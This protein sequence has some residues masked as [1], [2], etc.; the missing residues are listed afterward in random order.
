MTLRRREF[1]KRAAGASAS[2]ALGAP[3]VACREEMEPFLEDTTWDPRQVKH[4]LPI[5]NHERI[6]LKASFH[7]ALTKPPVLSIAG[8]ALSGTQRDST[9]HFFAF[10]AAGLAPDREYELALVSSSGTPLCDP[11]TLRTFPA[12]GD[13]PEHFRL[14]AY[15]CAGGSDLFWH[16]TQGRLFQPLQV[17]RRLLARALAFRPDAVIANGDH[18]YWDLRSRPG[19]LMGRSPQA[20]WVA[21]YFDREAAV[22]G[23]ENEEVLKAGFGPQIADLYGTLFRSVPAYFLQDDHD[24]TENDEANDEFRTFPP[25]PFMLDVARTTQRL[26]YPEFLAVPSLP[27]SFLAPGGLSESFGELRYGRLFEGLLYDCRRYLTND[28]DPETPHAKAHFVPEAAERWLHARTGASD[29]LHLA[30]VPST[31]ILWTAG[32]WGEWYPDVKDETGALSVEVPKPYWPEGWQ[33]Q[34]DRLV[35]AASARRDR[36]PLWVSGDLHATGIGRIHRTRAFSLEANPVVS[37]LSGTPGTDGPG[38]P[39]RFRGQRPVPSLTVEAE[40]WIEPIEENGFTILDFT[41][42]VVRLSFFRWKTADGIDAISRLEPFQ[43]RDI[44]R[45]SLSG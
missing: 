4:I 23:T 22:L 29:A 10:D 37:V 25:D 39:S 43:V 20:W 26:Y 21:G 16:P 44:P 7:A 30:H 27:A 5:A 13:L 15:T 18:V 32:K 41:P 40:E 31:P 34:H 38:W 9:G 17:R 3:L 8:R 28:R 45:P 33:E 36:T 14:L 19:I 12:P 6:R 42:E 35:R 24:Y 2:L 1:L 11:W